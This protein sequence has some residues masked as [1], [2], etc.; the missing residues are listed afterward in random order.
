MP[1]IAIGLAVLALG[2]LLLRWF[3]AMDPARLVQM[4]ATAAVALGGSLSLLLFVIGIA[5]RS[6]IFLLLGIAGFTALWHVLKQQR[7]SRTMSGSHMSAVETDYLSMRLE[8]DSGIMSGTVRKG[9]FQGRHLSELSRDQLLELWRVCRVDDAEAA[10]LMEAYLDR[11]A[12]GWRETAE[13]TGGAPPG[14]RGAPMTR[15]EACAV[16]GL[17]SDASAAEVREAHHRLMKAVH[18]DHGGSTYLAAKL[19]EARDVL[20]GG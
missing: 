8:H 4:G 14:A 5:E 12:P 9:P 18:P 1:Y 19:N 6:P 3:L 16:L 10:A 7:Q 2:W 20:L 17:G 15:A 13:S 11:L